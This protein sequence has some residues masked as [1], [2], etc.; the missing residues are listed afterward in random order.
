VGGALTNP[1]L[2]I[3]GGRFSFLQSVARIGKHD[4]EY[5][6]SFG[7]NVDWSLWINRSSEIAQLQRTKLRLFKN[8]AMNESPHPSQLNSRAR[9]S[10]DRS[11]VGRERGSR[12]GSADDEDLG[13]ANRCGVK[14]W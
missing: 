8:N 9:L 4:I 14:D 6:G 3:I 2:R 11:S 7:V 10:G 13:R 12:A 1:I 5:G